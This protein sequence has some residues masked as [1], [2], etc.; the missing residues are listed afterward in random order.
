M[1]VFE[2]IIFKDLYKSLYIF[3]LQYCRYSYKYCRYIVFGVCVYCRYLIVVK[4]SDMFEGIYDVDMRTC[5]KA[6]LNPEKK[7]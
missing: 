3:F 4:Y 6:R 1:I 7:V 2:V 5:L